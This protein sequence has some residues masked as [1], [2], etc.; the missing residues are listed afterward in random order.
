MFE[1]VMGFIWHKSLK[2]T[3]NSEDAKKTPWGRM[4]VVTA[5][6]NRGALGSSPQQLFSI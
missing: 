5:F 3:F 2:Q 4:L 1:D 6:L